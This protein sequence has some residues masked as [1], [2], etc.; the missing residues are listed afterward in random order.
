MT[1]TTGPEIFRAEAGGFVAKGPP[2]DLTLRSLKSSPAR[3]SNISCGSIRLK[4]DGLGPRLADISESA[5]P[6]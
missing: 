2:V 6:C 5:V 3:G 1:G 4:S